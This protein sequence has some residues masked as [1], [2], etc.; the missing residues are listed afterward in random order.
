VAHTPFDEDPLPQPSQ[1]LPVVQPAG[2]IRTFAPL[3][4][5]LKPVAEPPLS[6]PTR[7]FA[8]YPTDVHLSAISP[9][10]PP[11]NVAD[12]PVTAVP[13]HLTPLPGSIGDFAW[14]GEQ[15]SPEEASPAHSS[16]TGTIYHGPASSVFSSWE[17][18]EDAPS[19]PQTPPVSFS[20]N[21]YSSGLLS[22]LTPTWER[23][24]SEQPFVQAQASG[25]ALGN[26]YPGL[27]KNPQITNHLLDQLEVPEEEINRLVYPLPIWVSAIGILA[28]IFVLIGLIFLNGDWATGALISAVVAIVLAVLLLI[29]FGVRVALGLLSPA[30][31]HRIGQV[32]CTACLVLLLGAFSGYGLSQQRSLHAIQARYL[33]NQQDWSLAVAEFQA[34][35]ETAPTSLNLAR[36]YNEWGVALAERHDYA[37]AVARFN[38]VISI[39]A[40]AGSEVAQARSNILSAYFQWA[41]LAE[42]QKDYSHETVYYDTLLKLSYCQAAC[43]AQA[44]P[45]DANAYY[46]LAEQ[47]LGLQQYTL[48]VNAFNVLTTRF[49]N[50]PEVKGGHADYA[51]ALWG[52]GQ[53]QLTSTCSTAVQ[54]YRELAHQFADTSQGQQAATALAQPVSVKGH[55]ITPIPGPPANPT[56]SL[57]Q[58]MYFGIT[59]SQ[60]SRIVAAAPSTEVQSNGDFTFESV[61]QGTYTLVWSYDGEFNYAYGHNQNQ[62]LYTATLGPLCTYDYGDIDQTITAP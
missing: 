7:A 39:Y 44:T 8:D 26:V 32:I 16:G 33:E 56:V 28:G 4:A 58:G 36:V 10:F 25:P 2:D 5:V 49:P 61:P 54:T 30:N 21:P 3:P 59:D 51:K 34:A 50:A 15:L 27:P 47:Q 31:P 60:F 57:V 18:D 12:A 48:A 14:H 13:G 42:Q 43:Q 9:A 17:Q 45:A 41:S 19:F 37:D 40:Q 53:Q 1:P 46:D 24:E 23:E 22:G 55:F 62:V 38:T 6:I 20:R 11:G 35:G 29:A 52:L